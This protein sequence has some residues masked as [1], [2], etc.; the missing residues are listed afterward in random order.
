MP[1][2]S[3]DPDLFVLSLAWRD[4]TWTEKQIIVWRARRYVIGLWAMRAWVIAK[5]EVAG[6]AW[7]V[8]TA[9]AVSA[10]VALLLGGV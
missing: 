1:I 2:K 6:V 5:A 4:L 9:G 10:F 8:P 3:F 7:L